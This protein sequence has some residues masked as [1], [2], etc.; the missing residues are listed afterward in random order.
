[1]KTMPIWSLEEEQRLRNL[2]S[3]GES[4][5]NIALFLKRSPDAIAMKLKRMGI[6]IPEKH[7]VISEGNKV[8]KTTTTTTPKLKALKFEELPSPN[9]AMG[10]LWAA[11]KRLQDPDVGKEESKKLR[12]IIQGVKSYI[13]LDADYVFRI[14]EVERRMLAMYTAEVVHLQVLA[15]HAENPEEK[16]KLEAEIK[17]LQGHIVNMEAMGITEPKKPRKEAKPY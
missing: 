5:E 3:K 9:M 8:T 16:Q 4:I 13:H 2:V 15:D 7:S 14:R 17:E 11:V 10:L 12:L 1:M 6:T